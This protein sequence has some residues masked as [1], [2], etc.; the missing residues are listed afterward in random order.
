M[1]LKTILIGALVLTLCACSG[2]PKEEI[3]V[4]KV[5]IE[6]AQPLKLTDFVKS[7]TLVPLETN[8]TCLIKNIKKLVMQDRKVYIQNDR[9]DVLVFD[10][11]GKFLL[12]QPN[13]EGK[14]RKTISCYSVWM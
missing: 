8:E 7:I 5:D 12:R 9:Q 4:I 1:I 10:E 3:E 6:N 14:D 2:E 11:N 13:V